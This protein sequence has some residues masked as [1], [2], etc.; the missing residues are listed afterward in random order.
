MKKSDLKNLIKEVTFNQSWY[1]QNKRD[2]LYTLSALPE[3]DGGSKS[4]T[5]FTVKLNDFITARVNLYISKDDIGLLEG[6]L[7]KEKER[8]EKELK[9]QKIEKILQDQDLLQELMKRLQQT[10]K[11]QGK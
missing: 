2:L 10:Q 11:K 7:E 6:E 5:Q 3:S 8:E 4:I 9:E 1:E